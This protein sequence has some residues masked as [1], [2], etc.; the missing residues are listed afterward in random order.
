MQAV[1]DEFQAAEIG[2]R[3]NVTQFTSG[4]IG[5]GNTDLGSLLVG[6][7][8]SK[9]LTNEE[10]K[11]E[12]ARRN[13]VNT[14]VWTAEGGFYAEEEQ[15]S[16]VREDSMGGSYDFT[17][18]AGL[19]TEMGMSTGIHFEMD[20]L[21]GGHIRTRAVKTQREGVN[22]GL[23]VEVNG[24]RFINKLELGQQHIPIPGKVKGYRFMSF[25]MSPSKRNFEQFKGVV[26]QNWLNGQGPYAGQ[27]D[28]NAFALRQA[29]TRPNE[30]W[31][32]LHRVTYVSRVPDTA[33]HDEGESIGLDVLRP[34]AEMNATNALL[35]SQLPK[36]TDTMGPVRVALTTVLS[37]LEQNPLWGDRLRV[38]ELEVRSDIMQYMRGYYGI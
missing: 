34:S 38:E 22:F 6:V 32:V 10:W 8:G 2:R 36:T 19:Y 1:F 5:S 12:I 21:F 37:A 33:E 3:T 13:L 7:K 23:N 16:A 29:L 31:R 26:D 30:V 28:P 24:E 11:A 25:Y 20:A 9:Q 17:G 14:Y 27:N 35:L 15:F 18:L 4:D